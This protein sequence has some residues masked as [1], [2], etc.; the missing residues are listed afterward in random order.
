MA[1]FDLGN[2]VATRGVYDLMEASLDFNLFV[3]ASL[4]RHRIGDWGDLCTED[5][6]LNNASLHDGGRI[7]SAYEHPEH[8]DWKIWI[9]TEWDRSATTILFPSEY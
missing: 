7:M 3:G 1:K 2:T 5:K 4:N 9:I 6:Q 8:P